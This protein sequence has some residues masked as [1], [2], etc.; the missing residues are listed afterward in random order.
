MPE[1]TAGVPKRPGRLK[2]IEPMRIEVISEV[3]SS[4]AQARTYAE[5]KVFAA[6]AQHTQ[7]VRGARVVLRQDK[8]NGTS[9]SVAC[10]VTVALVP[11]GSV[12]TSACGPH[13]YAAINRTV[14]RLGDLMRRRVA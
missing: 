3:E 6:L 13:A 7:H 2:P 9:E 1:N 14:E 11:S 5:Y 4:N 10:A 8:R 12:R